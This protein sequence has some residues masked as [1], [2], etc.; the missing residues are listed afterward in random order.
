[1]E[2]I[3]GICGFLCFGCI[4]LIPIALIIWI[5][6]IIKKSEKKKNAKRF[7]LGALAGLVLFTV[8]G[9][10]TAPS[11]QCEHEWETIM[12][13]EPTC[14]ATGIAVRHCI[15]CD[16]NEDEQVIASLGHT[17]VEN[18]VQAASCS[19]AGVVEKTCSKCSQIENA[20]IG[21]INHDYKVT[22]TKSATLEERGVERSIFSVCGD[23][24]EKEIAKLGTKE[25]PGKVTIEQLVAE[26]NANI[27]SAKTK[28][29]GQWIEITGKVLTAD[30][31]AG[32]T[33]FYLYGK[34]GDSG[35]HICCWVKEA[36]Q[37]P[38]NY[39]GKVYTF[40]GQV[41][42]ITIMMATEIGD[43]QIIAE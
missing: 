27:D 13:N 11:N 20:S 15:I 3:S 7:F 30:N 10:I 23:V 6:R 36:V 14:T 19:N 26:I 9:V 29:N 4:L 12:Q 40:L 16:T 38:S 32:M 24:S 22:Y 39:Q 8:I 5:I 21:K 41:R 2:L 1:M 43:C 33:R 31:I 28:Y 34:T 35:L 18:I 37:E 42:E 17:F 25:K